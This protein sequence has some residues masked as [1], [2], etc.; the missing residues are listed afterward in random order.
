[1]SQSW[2]A[3]VDDDVVNLGCGMFVENVEDECYFSMRWQARPYAD[4][5][6]CFKQLVPPRIQDPKVGYKPN[7][8]WRGG[9]RR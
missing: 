4:A 8:L 9:V 6:Y 7:R 5:L 2:Q 3:A 1:M